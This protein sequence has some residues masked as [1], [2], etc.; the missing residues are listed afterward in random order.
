MAVQAVARL[1][2]GHGLCAGGATSRSVLER[3]KDL[4]SAGRA[5]GTAKAA[6]RKVAKYAKAAK[7]KKDFAFALLRAFVPLRGMSCFDFFTPSDA[8][9]YSMPPL[10]GPQKRARMRKTFLANL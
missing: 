3:W 5:R 4:T 7:K 8:L 1:A 2:P 6:S 10:T 9:G